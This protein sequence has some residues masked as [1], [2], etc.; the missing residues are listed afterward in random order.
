MNGIGKFSIA[1]AMTCV[2]MR[3]TKRY[4]NHRNKNAKNLGTA[5]CRDKGKTRGSP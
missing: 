4:A 3:N 1:G 2:A 5:P